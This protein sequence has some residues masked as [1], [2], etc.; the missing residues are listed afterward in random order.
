MLDISLFCLAVENSIRYFQTYFTQLILFIFFIAH[1]RI[2][3]SFLYL[4]RESFYNQKCFHESF[5]VF[6]KIIFCYLPCQID[7]NGLQIYSCRQYK[8]LEVCQNTLLYC[9]GKFV[10]Y[11]EAEQLSSFQTCNIR[12]LTR[13]CANFP[14]MALNLQYII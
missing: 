7:Y 14:P 4:R 9:S 11:L 12:L 1:C 8:R 13:T 6:L 5:T 3:S 10:N 2:F